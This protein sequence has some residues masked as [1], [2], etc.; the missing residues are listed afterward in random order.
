[1]DSPAL[2]GFPIA[3]ILQPWLVHVNL[4]LS[5]IN[6]AIV[7][8]FHTFTRYGVLVQSWNRHLIMFRSLQLPSTT[9]NTKHWT[10]F[11]YDWAERRNSLDRCTEVWYWIGGWKL[12]W[13]QKLLHYIV[14]GWSSQLPLFTNSAIDGTV[15]RSKLGSA[16]AANN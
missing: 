3:G 10:I 16:V 14:W 1:M 5:C 2:V 12:L 7:W 15:H 4:L 13:Q 9:E 8:N 6:N 11:P